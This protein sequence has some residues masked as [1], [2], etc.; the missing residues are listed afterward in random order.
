[1]EIMRIS[2][3]GC[4]WKCECEG[5]A[6]LEIMGGSL[7][8]LRTPG[9]DPELSDGYRRNSNDQDLRTPSFAP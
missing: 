3:R 1:M 6:R 2:A 5:L 8:D 7:C 4:E 9:I